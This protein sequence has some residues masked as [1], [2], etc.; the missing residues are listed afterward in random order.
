M[1]NYVFGAL[2]WTGDSVCFFRLVFFLLFY[3]VR[4]GEILQLLA[5]GG[6]DECII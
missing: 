1:V 6:T 3:Q 4:Q 2:V 5:Q